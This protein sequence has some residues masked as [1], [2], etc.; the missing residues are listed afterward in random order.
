MSTDHL[1]L[2]PEPLAPPVDALIGQVLDG[3][4]QIEK[5]LG[6]GGMGLVYKARHVSLGKPL[7]IKVL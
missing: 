3:R 2:V 4:Y 1:K 6:E 5:I 7:A